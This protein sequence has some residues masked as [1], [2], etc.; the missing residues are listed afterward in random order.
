MRLFCGLL[1]VL[2]EQA[3]AYTT[4]TTYVTLAEGNPTGTLIFTKMARSPFDCIAEC[5]ALQSEMFEFVAPM[6]SCFDTPGS[7]FVLFGT[8]QVKT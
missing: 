1:L 2:I 8:V 7:A 5:I 6:C 4:S 3:C